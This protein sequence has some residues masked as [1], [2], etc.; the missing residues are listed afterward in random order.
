[1]PCFALW[2]RTLKIDASEFSTTSTFI[3]RAKGNGRDLILK[4]FLLVVTGQG[5]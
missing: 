5:K 3:C 2:G 1:M 4:K